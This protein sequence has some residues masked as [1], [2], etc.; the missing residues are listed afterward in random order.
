MITYESNRIREGWFGLDVPGRGTN[1]EGRLGD[2]QYDNYAII[3]L[4][5]SRLSE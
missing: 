2:P 1:R 3:A 5:L 4:F